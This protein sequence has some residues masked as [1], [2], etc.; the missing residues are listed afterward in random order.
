MKANGLSKIQWLLTGLTLAVSLAGA[1]L[2]NGDGFPVGCPDEWARQLL[3]DF[4]YKHNCLPMGRESEIIIGT[5]G[6]SYALR[7]YVTAIFG[8][9]CMK[10][11]SVFSA[12]SHALLFASRLCSVCSITMCFYFSCKLGNKLF[13]KRSSTT[14]FSL[15]ICFLPQ[16]MFLGMYQNND[17]LSLM[18]AVMLLYFLISGQR[19]HWAVKDCMG[20]GVGLSLGLLSY[21]SIYGWLLVGG[22][23]FLYTLFTDRT[24]STRKRF[25]KMGLIASVVLLLAGWF[26]IRNAVLHNGDFFG[27]ATEDAWRAELEAQGVEIF[28]Y[29]TP[30]KW[31]NASF[32]NFITYE[33]FHWIRTTQKSFIG[34]FGF[35]NVL[36]KQEMYYIYYALFGVG[37]L[38]YISV[39]LRCRKT[40]E[41]RMF[42][43]IL[44]ISSVITLGLS[45]YQSYFRDYQA[46]G[47]YIISAVILFAY[48]MA[49]SSDM[50]EVSLDGAIDVQEKRGWA[51]SK[52]RVDIAFSVIWVALF[53]KA[54]LGTISKMFIK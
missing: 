12:S 43:Y 51:P 16:V 40:K 20:F 23:S 31:E 4:I 1:W 46:Q 29:K 37:I 30:S 3:S 39:T 44:L 13:A 22:V 53:F 26:F 10:I 27:M 33:D 36:M 45:L 25:E 42:F 5:Y 28:H 38:L 54:F 41:H 15:V 52:V 19:S 7:P 48:M 9:L 49:Y 35:M 47:R 24:V 50:L 14:L 8:A 34:I 2:I 21:Y 32:W 17:M 6:F 11:V 18:S